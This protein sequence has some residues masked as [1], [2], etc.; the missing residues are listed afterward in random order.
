MI[1]QHTHMPWKW[2]SD[3]Q[4]A[5]LSRPFPSWCL[6]IIEHLKMN[7]SLQQHERDY[8]KSGQDKDFLHPVL[9]FNIR[10]TSYYILTGRSSMGQTCTY[11]R[12][13]YYFMHA[14]IVGIP[15]EKQIQS[16]NLT[17]PSNSQVPQTMM[18]LLPNI[19]HLRIYGTKWR[20]RLWLKDWWNC[21][22]NLWFSNSNRSSWGWCC[23]YWDL[24]AT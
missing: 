10:Q 6:A 1:Q 8:E 5:N 9:W 2:I 16:S 3:T 14:H 21:V 13:L 7:V 19:E 24:Q 17:N 15:I 22:Y 20:N 11:Q 4:V 18:D 23:L 12:S